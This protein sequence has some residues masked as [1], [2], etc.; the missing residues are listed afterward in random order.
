MIV[1]HAC[2]VPDEPPDRVGSVGQGS[3]KRV[4]I[5][6]VDRLVH[7]LIDPVEEIDEDFVEFHG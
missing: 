1:L 3:P 6:A 2:E 5:E 7:M 4:G